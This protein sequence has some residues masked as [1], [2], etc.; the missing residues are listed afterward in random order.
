MRVPWRGRTV[1]T[2]ALEAARLY[3]GVSLRLIL[4]DAPGRRPGLDPYVLTAA[5]LIW[6]ELHMAYSTPS[7][8]AGTLRRG[9]LRLAQLPCPR[10]IES[11]AWEG[12]G[13]GERHREL[14]PVVT[15]RL[16]R[17]AHRLREVPGEPLRQGARARS[18]A[19][20]TGHADA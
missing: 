15:G 5:P 2:D 12:G 18:A 4:R 20:A 17:A 10:R 13:K 19:G 6:N 1:C 9:V 11:G 16:E 7:S 3:A 14:P 8:A